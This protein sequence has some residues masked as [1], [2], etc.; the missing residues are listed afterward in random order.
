MEKL[1]QLTS[2]VTEALGRVANKLLGPTE[3]TPEYREQLSKL[4]ATLMEPYRPEEVQGEFGWTDQG[5]YL[6][7]EQ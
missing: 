4:S 5:E 3:C 7:R 2:K 1:P 6:N